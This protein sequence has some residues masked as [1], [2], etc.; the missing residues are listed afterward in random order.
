MSAKQNLVIDGRRLWDSIMETAA[1]GATPKGGIK[2]LTLSD[3]SILYF[4]PEPG[5]APTEP[6]EWSSYARTRW[7]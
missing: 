2:R 6:P 3:G 5:D 4:N 7:L 1:F